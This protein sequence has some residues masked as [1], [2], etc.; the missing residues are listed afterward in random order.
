MY[1]SLYTLTNR[2]IMHVMSPE[3]NIKKNITSSFYIELLIKIYIHQQH[4]R[5]LDELS[6][7]IRN[8]L[9]SILLQIELISLQILSRNGVPTTMN[10]IL[11]CDKK[12]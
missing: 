6:P 9:I 11:L 8:I 7:L 10:I 3:V 12:K 5:K 2:C 4:V 1:E